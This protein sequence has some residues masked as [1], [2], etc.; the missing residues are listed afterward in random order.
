VSGAD[1]AATDED[2]TANVAESKSPAITSPSDQLHPI[3]LEQCTELGND[4]KCHEIV[5]TTCKTEVHN[6]SVYEHLMQHFF[7]SQDLDSTPP[8][9]TTENVQTD[10]S[11]LEKLVQETADVQLAAEAMG[12][13]SEEDTLAHWV[14]EARLNGEP[15]R[16]R[17]KKG[18]RSG[19]R[20]V[21]RSRGPDVVERNTV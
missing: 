7:E 18:P 20:P 13:L 6:N 21:T 1:D 15:T 5:E 19:T 16:K 3:L 12:R 2:T 11:V 8:S 10:P 17:L 9:P 14:L 4:V